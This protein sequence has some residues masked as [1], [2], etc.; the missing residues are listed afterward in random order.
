[1]YYKWLLLVTSYILSGLLSL[2]TFVCLVL[3][4]PRVRRAYHNRRQERTNTDYIN[5]TS[6]LLQ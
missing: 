3:L 1:M 2:L 5:E 4:V 6:P